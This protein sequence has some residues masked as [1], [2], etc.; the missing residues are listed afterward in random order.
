MKTAVTGVDPRAYV[1]SFITEDVEACFKSEQ[2]EQPVLE[3][4]GAPSGPR[5]APVRVVVAV[6]GPGSMAGRL[7]GQTKLDLGRRAALAFVDGLPDT[8]ET[9]LLVFG[10]QGSTATPARPGP[11]P[12]STCS[13]R[14]RPIARGWSMA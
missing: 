7:G 12:A 10:Q 2:M 3:A 6:D 5:A 13:R 11:A 4:K 9:S 1:A 14:C 8:V